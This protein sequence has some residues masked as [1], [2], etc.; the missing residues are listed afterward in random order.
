[1]A[2]ARN[3]QFSG[4]ST[5]PP[6]TAVVPPL[7]HHNISSSSYQPD[8]VTPQQ[9]EELHTAF[10]I[11]QSEVYQSVD[12]LRQNQQSFQTSLT[13]N[14]TSFQNHI[15]AQIENIQ[16]TVC[17]HPEFHLKTEV[18]SAGSTYKENLLKIRHYLP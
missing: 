13:Q 12:S 1:M 6:S 2:P 9:V 14:Q 10:E 11:L 16:S 8:K 17:T 3:L 5:I 7:P 15:S 4:P 18:N